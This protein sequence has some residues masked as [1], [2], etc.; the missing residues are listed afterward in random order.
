MMFRNGSL[1][2][3]QA[4]K[5]NEMARQL[6]QL[7]RLT[8]AA[9]LGMSRVGG[10]PVIT[11][12]GL[13]GFPA[14]LT[15]TFDSATGYDWTRCRIDRSTAT[16]SVETDPQTGSY[17]FTPDNNETL[18]IGDRGWLEADPNSGGWIFI[19]EVAGSG[20]VSFLN[21][22]AHGSGGT[23]YS[24]TADSTFQATGMTLAIPSAGTY[25]IKAQVSAHGALTGGTG[26]IGGR[27][28]IIVRLYSNSGATARG[29][30]AVAVACS[31]VSG[32]N[33]LSTGTVTI[34]VPVTFSG[35]DTVELY[36]ERTP[37]FDSANGQTWSTAVIVNNEAFLD[38][39]GSTTT[40]G[41]ELSYIKFS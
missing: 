6:D 25:L 23:N 33:I 31:G 13:Q 16:P 34:A 10:S 2:S 37:P 12:P 28:L 30:K 40:D 26:G 1:T 8:V 7:S 36:A 24:I 15:S 18:S 3:S 39:N 41:T 9:P 22:S 32:N 4:A 38:L 14:E 27:S 35:S 11:A 20:S 21:D 17:A 29:I 19:P 5:L